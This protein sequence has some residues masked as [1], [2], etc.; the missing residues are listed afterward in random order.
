MRQRSK[1]LFDAVSSDN[2]FPV[3]AEA[4]RSCLNDSFDMPG[5]K[6]LLGEIHDGTV[7]L[8]FFYTS[9]PSPFSQNLVRD[10][11]ISLLYEYDERK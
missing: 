10:E 9:R 1:R 2:G 11:T 7:S 8:S 6:N 4:W 5:F 3:T